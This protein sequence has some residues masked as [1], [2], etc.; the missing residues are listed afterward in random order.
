MKKYVSKKQYS[1]AAILS[2]IFAAILLTTFY[3]TLKTEIRQS[4]NQ[5][6]TRTLEKFLHYRSQSENLFNLN[7][8]ILKGYVA[9]IKTHPDAK[10]EELNNYLSKLIGEK[11]HLIK[12][13]STLKNTTIVTVYPLQGNES[14]IGADISKVPGQSEKVLAVKESSEKIL[15]GPLKLLQG[16]LG[17][18]LRIPVIIDDSYWGQ[19]SLIIDADKFIDKALTFGKESE[20]EI[21]L[22]N[23]EKFQIVPFIGDR[24]ILRKDPIILNM[25]LENAIWK[26]AIIPE[27][28]WSDSNN[29]L[30]TKFMILSLLTLITSMLI[31]NNIISGFKLKNQVMHDQLT[32]LYTR[33]FLDEFYPLVFEKSV[34]NGTKVGILLLDINN[35]KVINDTYGHKVGDEVLRAISDQLLK[36]CRKSEAVFRL[37][38]DE[39]LIIISDITDISNIESIKER[40]TKATSLEHF[41]KKH[42]ISLSSS[43]G[44]A[45]YPLDGSTFDEVVHVADK[46]MYMQKNLFKIR[47]I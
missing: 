1:I 8:N 27:K 40:I 21:A 45:I 10:H 17:F 37:G 44:S 33:F 41:Y 4:K 18:I 19:V 32:G 7:S 39:F 42:K 12:N 22:F 28:G 2:F 5:E 47:K 34:R 16:G 15:Q 29:I 31:Y 38:G 30:F 14:V 13:I 20:L 43:L 24:N 23:D 9:Y 26:A 25:E 3:S 36:V 35:F 11:E 46:D 6:R